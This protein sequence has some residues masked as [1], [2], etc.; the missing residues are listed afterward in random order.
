MSNESFDIDD[1]LFEGRVAQPPPHSPR[2]DNP[3]D[4]LLFAGIEDEPTSWDSEDM[5]D[6]ISR[7]APCEAS[8]STDITSN[9][10]AQTGTSPHIHTGKPKRT[11]DR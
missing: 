8:G 5:L 9:S 4:D 7:T 6:L 11:R 10:I 2:S 1:L 3:D